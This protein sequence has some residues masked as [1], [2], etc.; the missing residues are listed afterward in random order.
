MT[1]D[2]EYK[3]DPAPYAVKQTPRGS[4]V[5]CRGHL[6]TDEIKTGEA[7]ALAHALNMEHRTRM[8]G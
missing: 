1:P 3:H 5:V 8:A 4:V 6:V 7:H 2:D